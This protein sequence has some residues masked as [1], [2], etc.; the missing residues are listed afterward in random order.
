[1]ATFV[2]P[3]LVDFGECWACKD[4]IGWVEPPAGKMVA[5]NPTPSYHGS[6]ALLADGKR[7]IDL[8]LPVHWM[9]PVDRTGDVRHILYVR[10]NLVC[11]AR[12]L[13]SMPWLVKHQ[14]RPPNDIREDNGRPSWR[15]TAP[16]TAGRATGAKSYLG[17]PAQGLGLDPGADLGVTW[18]QAAVYQTQVSDGEAAGVCSGYNTPGGR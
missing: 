5:V 8:D 1:M 11:E 4:Q 3:Q 14:G 15:P 2:V 6:I 10:H 7:G 16:G 12:G 13:R 18:D 17:T 9:P